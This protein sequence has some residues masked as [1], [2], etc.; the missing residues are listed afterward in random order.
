MIALMDGPVEFH[1]CDDVT[2][3]MDGG[4]DSAG[5]VQ[6]IRGKVAS[7]KMKSMMADTA[8]LHEMRPDIL[9]ATLAIEDDGTFTETMAFTDEAAPARA[10]EGDAD[11]GRGPRDLEMAMKDVT[12]YDLH[13]PWFASA[14][15]SGADRARRSGRHGGDD[16]GALNRVPPVARVRSSR[17]ADQ[18]RNGTAT[19]SDTCQAG[20]RA[21]PE[22]T[23]PV[24]VVLTASRVE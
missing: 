19:S 24:R 23:T 17:V 16:P 21:R 12:Y 9:G 22:N 5:F 7:R 4:S 11:A 14:R 13:R 15:A 3:M 10:R 1:D 18:A 20:T 8:M 2:L 6:I